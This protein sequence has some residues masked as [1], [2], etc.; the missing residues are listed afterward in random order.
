M[1]N[2]SEILGGDLGS[3]FFQ[4]FGDGT[5]FFV[6]PMQ[7]VFGERRLSCRLRYTCYIKLCDVIRRPWLKSITDLL[8]TAVKRGSNFKGYL[9]PVDPR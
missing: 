4:N 9:W 3:S 1:P 2:F 8:R 6:F 7:F 5:Y